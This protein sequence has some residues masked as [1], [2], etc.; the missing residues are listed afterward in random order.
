LSACNGDEH[1]FVEVERAGNA[2]LREDT[3]D[4]T[5]RIADSEPLPNDGL[6]HDDFFGDDIPDDTNGRC[7]IDVEL[8]KKSSARH[9][10]ALDPLQS[11]IRSK[12]RNLA[13]SRSPGY[14]AATDHDR[15]NS[16]NALITQQGA[17]VVQGEIAGRFADQQAS[18]ART[19]G[20]GLAGQ[21]D[22]R[23]GAE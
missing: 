19:R 17:R 23:I 1:G 8:R 18:N 2:A 22:Q 5:A 21:N 3:D 7:R 12:Y 14:E 16:R 13:G 10:P 9:F 6:C 4:S 20:I 15:R 11:G